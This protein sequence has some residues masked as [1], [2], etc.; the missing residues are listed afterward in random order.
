M[1]EIVLIHNILSL[2]LLSVL[3]LAFNH[4]AVFFCCFCVSASF[5]IVNSDLLE[6]FVEWVEFAFQ[7]TCVILLVVG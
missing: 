7:S 3:L 1:S 6:F 4:S 5:L 2:T